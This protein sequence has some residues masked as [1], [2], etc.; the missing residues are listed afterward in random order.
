VTLGMNVRNITGNVYGDV[1][2]V[3]NGNYGKGVNPDVNTYGIGGVP[4]TLYY[5][6]PDAQ[7]TEYQIYLRTKF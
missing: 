5:Y 3:T 7:P 4:N 6:A 2:P 1:F